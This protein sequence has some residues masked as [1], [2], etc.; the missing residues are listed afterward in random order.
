M[1]TNMRYSPCIRLGNIEQEER[2]EEDVDGVGAGDVT[3]GG[4]SGLVLNGGGLGSEGI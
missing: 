2:T 4:V 3:N 1:S